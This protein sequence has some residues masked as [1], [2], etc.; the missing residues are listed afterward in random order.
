[1]KFL[2][3]GIF[4]LAVSGVPYA[5]TTCV[6]RCEKHVGVGDKD[7]PEMCKGVDERIKRKKK[8]SDAEAAF[9]AGAGAAASGSAFASVP[10]NE[11]VT[12]KAAKPAT[13]KPQADK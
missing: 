13:D 3:V 7:C 6:E 10:K 4:M 9:A 5:Q 11:A 2:I 8:D 12:P 1:M